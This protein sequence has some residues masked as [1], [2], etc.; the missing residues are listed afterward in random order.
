TKVEQ[1]SSQLYT[2]TANT[3]YQVKDVLIDGINIGAP[4]SY[5]F[6]DVTTSHSI[7][8]DFSLSVGSSPLS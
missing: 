6:D 7:V 5:Q 8:V 3:G 1:G 2:F 4:A